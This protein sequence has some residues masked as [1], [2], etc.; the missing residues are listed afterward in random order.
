MG[1]FV[2]N[3]NFLPQIA[4]MLGGIPDKLVTEAATQ[5]MQQAKENCPVDTGSLQSTIYV[6][7]NSTSTYG[8]GFE[9][10]IGDSYFLEEIEQPP[11]GT[12]YVAVADNYGIYV[13]MG[14]RFMGAEPYLIPALMTVQSSFQD[15]TMLQQLLT[16]GIAAL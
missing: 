1:S 10:P 14:T 8:Q 9:A 11:S 5:I 16:E 15:G 2:A 3:F 7:T 4:E 13:E 6:K 12:A